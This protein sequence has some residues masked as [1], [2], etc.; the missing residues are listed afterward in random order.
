MT[1]RGVTGHVRSRTVRAADALSATPPS[2]RT[3]DARGG[4]ASRPSR[5]SRTTP[6]ARPAHPGGYLPFGIGP[7][8][9]VGLR[10]A[11]RES[12][13]LLEH[14][15]PAH[16]PVFRSTPT[17]AAYSITVRPAGSTPATLASDA[18]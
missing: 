11:L 15:L 10:F 5:P 9:C 14:L 18:L 6:G 1:R 8:A 2:G 12:T 17:R 4:K 7:R 13:V 16:A 3:G